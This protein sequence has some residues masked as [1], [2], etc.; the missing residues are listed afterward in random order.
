MVYCPYGLVSESIYHR[1]T[2]FPSQYTIESMV[3]CSHLEI[4][5]TPVGYEELARGFEPIRNGDV[6]HQIPTYKADAP[7][8]I[9]SV[10]FTRRDTRNRSYGSR[11]RLANT[12]IK[13]LP[14]LNLMSNENGA[15]LHI[16]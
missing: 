13:D 4:W 15:I 5:S 8:K 10:K 14:D 11:R 16:T 6:A 12:K 9:I 7:P 3:Y 1:L 2:S